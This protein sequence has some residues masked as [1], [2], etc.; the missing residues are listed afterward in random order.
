MRPLRQRWV[1]V[2]VDLWDEVV[3]L[4]HPYYERADADAEARE[5]NERWQGH[6]DRYVVCE[7][8]RVAATVED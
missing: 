6:R 1:V 8:V 5:D 2:E 7:L 4:T 3:N